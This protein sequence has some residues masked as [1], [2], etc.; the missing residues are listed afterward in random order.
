MNSR[1]K[2]IRILRRDEHTALVEL[3]DEISGKKAVCRKVSLEADPVLIHQLRQEASLLSM[4]DHSGIPAL[5]DA[6]EEEGT[7]CLIRSWCSGKTLAERLEEKPSSAEKKK[8][9]LQVMTLLEQIH[10]QGY[11]YLDLKP[12]NILVDEKGKVSLVDFN[13][14]IPTG[15]RKVLL[16]NPQALPPEANGSTALD[17]KA[18]QWGLG[19]LYLRLFRKDR[20][21]RRLLRHNPQK[22]YDSLKE[23]R[24]DLTPLVSSRT[25]YGLLV[26]MGALLISSV[27]GASAFWKEDTP[28][29]SR[30]IFS[31]LE[32]PGLDEEEQKERFYTLLCQRGLEQRLLEEPDLVLV[33][34]QKGLSLQ[35]P[36]LCRLLLQRI[37]DQENFDSLH[38]LTAAA[39]GQQTSSEQISTLLEQLQDQLDGCRQAALLCESLLLQNLKL[40]REQTILLLGIAE[41]HQPD[42]E[43]ARSMAAYLLWLQAQGADRQHWP[44]AL[45]SA[46]QKEQEGRNLLE[47]YLKAAKVPENSH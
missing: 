25:R 31:L 23:C 19:Q 44:K 37:P 3:H 1:W 10:E 15:S 21:A 6:F 35:D 29:V 22:R 5:L 26:L 28:A 33:L 13:S 46:L 42:P 4:L 30:D 36:G 11:L 17:E 39:C 7:L 24:A 27:T 8:I 2:T 14:V 32:E 16:S 9:F 18:D 34:L 40:S 43:E 20:I 47:L 41:H 38:L 45:Q 12:D